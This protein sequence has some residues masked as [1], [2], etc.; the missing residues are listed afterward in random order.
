MSQNK[1]KKKEHRKEMREL[2]ETQKEE[3][4]KI[5][6]I[7]GECYR[8]ENRPDFDICGECMKKGKTPL[9]YN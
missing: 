8:C 2:R 3:G 9:N 4:I 6:R 7:E 5:E 1:K